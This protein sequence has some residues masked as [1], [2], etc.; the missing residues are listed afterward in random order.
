MLQ[1][2]TR[3]TAVERCRALQ[4]LPVTIKSIPT[5]TVYDLNK[6]H[7]FLKHKKLGDGVRLVVVL[8]FGDGKHFS[9]VCIIEA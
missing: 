4:R 6:L 2:L 9:A 5:Q 8:L 1:N 7:E 3:R